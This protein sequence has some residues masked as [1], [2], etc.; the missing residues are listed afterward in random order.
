MMRA[1]FNKYIGTHEEVFHQAITR[2][3][4]QATMEQLEQAP[5]PIASGWASCCCCR[6]PPRL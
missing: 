1:T 6:P 2:A 4:S 5:D 3:M